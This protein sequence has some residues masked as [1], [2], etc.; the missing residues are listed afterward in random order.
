M[1]RFVPLREKRP[2]VPP[3]ILCLI[4]RVVPIKDVKTFIRAMQTVVNR[5]PQAQ[6]WIMGPEDEDPQY[7]E[8]CH[9]LTDSLGLTQNVKFLGFQ[10]ITNILPQIGLLILS[11]ISEAM[12][13]VLLEGFA[14]GVP[15]VTTDVGSCSGL[16]Y[17]NSPQDK[18]IGAAGR[19]VHIAA[20][21]ALAEA[22]L[23]LLSQQAKWQAAQQAGIQRVEAYYTKAQMVAQYRQVYERGLGGWQE[24]ALNSARS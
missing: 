9:Y 4:G 19:V 6:G 1:E 3:P 23:D 22:A 17:G 5:I 16:I 21:Q 15:A 7:T 10:N 2:A 20:P 18:A 14:A 8:E 24:S 13:L 12:P 11:S